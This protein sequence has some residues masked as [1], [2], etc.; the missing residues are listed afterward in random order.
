MGFIKLTQ[1]LSEIMEEEVH[2]IYCSLPPEGVCMTAL[3]HKN[4]QIVCEQRWRLIWIVFL[5]SCTAFAA[6]G[7]VINIKKVHHQQSGIAAEDIGVRLPPFAKAA[8]PP[9]SANGSVRYAILNVSILKGAHSDHFY[10][11]F[12]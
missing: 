12:H 6:L 3:I 10:L 8:F 4:N 2:V 9:S 1:V 5:M 7:V 11:P